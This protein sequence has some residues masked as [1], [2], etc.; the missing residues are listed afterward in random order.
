MVINP[1]LDVV[2]LLKSLLRASCI[3]SSPLERPTRGG[4]RHGTRAQVR[5]CRVDKSKGLS[6]SSQ[7]G[8][9]DVTSPGPSCLRLLTE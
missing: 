4:Y 6:S 3:A 5:P 2:S 8:T 1:A 7:A 9:V